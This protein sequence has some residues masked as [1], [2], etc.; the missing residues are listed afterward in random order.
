MQTVDYSALYPNLEVILPEIIVTVFAVA[1][2]FVDLFTKGE[3]KTTILP[4]VSIVGYALAVVACALY[5]NNYIGSSAF[6]KE[7][8]GGMMV[9]DNLGLF[10]RIISLLTA[11]LAVLLS[12]LFIKEHGMALGEYYAVLA[13]ATLG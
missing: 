10:L 4:A 9:M 12:T 1:V 5:F 2:I 3:R 6:N 8:F 11:I 7:A 13:L